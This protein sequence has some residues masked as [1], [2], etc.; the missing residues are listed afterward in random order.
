MAERWTDLVRVPAGTRRLGLS[1]SW[2]GV[3]RDLDL[4]VVSPRGQVYGRF[5]DPAP[6]SAAANALGFALANPEAGQW[7]VVVTGMRGTGERMAFALES[8]RQ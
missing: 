2:K 1:L 3:G 4:A 5:A 7:R 6:I 8:T